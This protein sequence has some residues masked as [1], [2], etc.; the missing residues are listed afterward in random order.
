MTIHI[1][2]DLPLTLNLWAILDI[3]R[4]WLLEMSLNDPNSIESF[5]KESCSILGVGSSVQVFLSLLFPFSD[6]CL[7]HCY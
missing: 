1:D 4:G 7:K 2:T 3:I 5:K 6:N